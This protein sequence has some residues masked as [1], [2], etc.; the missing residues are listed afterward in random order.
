MGNFFFA[1]SSAQLPND[2][3]KKN[4]IHDAILESERLPLTGRHHHRDGTF[5]PPI[6][7]PGSP[8]QVVLLLSPFNISFRNKRIGRNIPVIS[9]SPFI[10]EY[11]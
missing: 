6:S 9:I 10:F 1:R 2:S 7:A 8:S 3:P 11:P 5:S 4:E